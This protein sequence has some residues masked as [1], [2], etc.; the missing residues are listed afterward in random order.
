MKK[1]ESKNSKFYAS[2]EIKKLLKA[3]RECV[4][5]GAVGNIVAINARLMFLARKLKL[6]Y[7]TL[8]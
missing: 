2:E 8:D 5:M 6:D 3:R 1:N 7:Y 4:A